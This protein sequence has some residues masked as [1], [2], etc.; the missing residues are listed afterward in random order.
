MSISNI[1]RALYERN[2]MAAVINELEEEL[3]NALAE[4]DALLVDKERMD[5]L[6][7]ATSI[8]FE[9]IE[10]RK[11]CSLVRD[12]IDCLMKEDRQ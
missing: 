11:W 12:T 10:E 2:N 8:E 4:R 3:G 6:E 9:E 1:D 7:S 5:W